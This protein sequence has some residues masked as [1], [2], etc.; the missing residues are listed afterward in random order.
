[1]GVLIV[2][3]SKCL[4]SSF[5]SSEVK[6]NLPLPSGKN[7]GIFTQ[8][9]D[10]L[11]KSTL[12]VK[13]DDLPN[14]SRN[15]FIGN[16]DESK[17]VISDNANNFAEV[18]FGGY[19]RQK[20]CDDHMNNYYLRKY[21]VKWSEAGILPVLSDTQ[22]DS[23]N[24]SL[25]EYF[26][27][28]NTQP[29]ITQPDSSKSFKALTAPQE[30]SFTIWEK[31]GHFFDSIAY[32]FGFSSDDRYERYNLANSLQNQP[33]KWN[34]VMRSYRDLYS[35]KEKP[36]DNISRLARTTI[37]LYLSLYK[38][39]ENAAVK[40][41]ERI[42]N[43]IKGSND[44]VKALEFYLRE[45]RVQMKQYSSKREELGLLKAAL[46]ELILLNTDPEKNKPEP[47]PVQ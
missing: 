18:E 36:Q 3:I 19:S 10:D 25:S 26:S 21:G 46:D 11:D 17:S 14:L 13:N 42:K 31:I 32:Y 7:S 37:S 24:E 1:L 28:S 41:K 5:I 39:E 47:K 4:D 15:Y 33:D 38:D 20:F 35:S 16:F 34:D 30:P 6:F 22:P 27:K 43:Q 29:V 40:L 12:T 8:C 23:C 45:I 9:K 44:Q 2:T